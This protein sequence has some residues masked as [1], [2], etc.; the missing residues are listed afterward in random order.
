MR[1]LTPLFVSYSDFDSHR[2]ELFPG[3]YPGKERKGKEEYLYSAI[4]VLCISQSAQARITQF[5]LPFIR[6]RLPDGATFN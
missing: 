5:C 3:C 1:R 4:Y 2:P 6:K